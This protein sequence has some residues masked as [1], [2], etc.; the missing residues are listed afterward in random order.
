MFS[1]L[2]VAFTACFTTSVLANTGL[3]ASLDVAIIEQAKDV[4]MDK[5]LE[6]LN[7]LQL[8]DIVSEDGKSYFK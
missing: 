2:L 1:K 5:I 4:Y 8:P 6:A 3:H 7:N